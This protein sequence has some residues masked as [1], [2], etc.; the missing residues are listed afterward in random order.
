ML[1]I[2]VGVEAAVSVAAA[3]GVG[4]EALLGA[5]GLAVAEVPGRG[6]AGASDAE[7]LGA[8]HEVSHLGLPGLVVGAY[9]GD[10]G[11]HLRDEFLQRRGVVGD[12][13]QLAC[14]VCPQVLAA[15]LQRGDP[16]VEVRCGVGGGAQHALSIDSAEVEL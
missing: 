10:V 8:V 11:A 2:A 1:V 15:G 6:A 4:G 12:G 9:S 16:L 7:E 14:F 3:G 5:Q 13:A